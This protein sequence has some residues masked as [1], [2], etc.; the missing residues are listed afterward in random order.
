VGLIHITGDLAIDPEEI[1]MTYIRASGPGGQ[2]INKTS[3]AVQLRFDAARSPSLPE[4]V[5][6]R[7]ISLAGKR[8]TRDGVLII[9]ARRFRSRERN[10]QD[11]ISRLTA[12]ARRAAEEPVQRLETRPTT[13]SDRHRLEQ[14]RRRGR[15]KE[16]RREA[17]HEE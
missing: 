12:L 4:E 6:R 1:Q 7:I 8:V 10:R 13:G 2:K 17:L 5:R 11:A 16:L 14:K 3:S 15:T 9:N